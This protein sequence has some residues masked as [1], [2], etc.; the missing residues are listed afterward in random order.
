M[1][2]DYEGE[3]L[4]VFPLVSRSLIVNQ[5]CHAVRQGARTVDEVLKAVTTDAHSRKDHGFSEQG[6]SQAMLLAQLGDAETR[7]E[8]R[9]FAQHI[10]DRERLPW[11]EKLRLKTEAQHDYQQ[12]YMASQPPTLKQLS[13]LKS[14]GCDTKPEN[15]LEASN[16]IEQHKNAVQR[17]Q[18]SAGR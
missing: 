3:F 12:A 15:R 10:I 2:W 5:F 7:E 4:K 18:Q 6:E 11:E 16:L 8:A 13:Y 1:K 17:P 14:L 9:R